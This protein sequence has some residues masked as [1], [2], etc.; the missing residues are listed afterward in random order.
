MGTDPVSETMGSL[1]HWMMDKAQRPGNP[2]CYTP[3]SETFR[4]TWNMVVIGDSVRSF[5]TKKKK[6]QQII[7]AQRHINHKLHQCKWDICQLAKHCI[8]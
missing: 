1:Q 3:S 6:V 7:K 2:E 5:S 4:I 8:C